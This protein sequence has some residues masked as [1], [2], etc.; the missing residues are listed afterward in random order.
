MSG[1]SLSI[2]LA[3]ALLCA[4]PIAAADGCVATLCTSQE[5]DGLENCAVIREEAWESFQATFEAEG[6]RARVS[7][8]QDCDRSEGSTWTSVERAYSAEAGWGDARFWLE[9][10]EVHE[11][12]EWADNYTYE[13]DTLAFGLGVGPHYLTG[14]WVKYRCCKPRPASCKIV[15]SFWTPSMDPKWV[16][17]PCPVGPPPP[18]PGT[19][20][21]P[22][23]LP[24]SLP[25]VPPIL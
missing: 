25:P 17:Q 6:A 1:P 3:L 14:E 13:D 15:A 12:D 21:N 22:P 20:P 9:W 5:G 19:H 23:S 11:G 16:R 7:E 4:T 2:A 8:R 18:P 24:P 10:R